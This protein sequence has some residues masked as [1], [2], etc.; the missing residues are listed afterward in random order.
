MEKQNIRPQTKA[1]E[2]SVKNSMKIILEHANSR[3]DVLVHSLNF[4]DADQAM[5][6]LRTKVSNRLSLS[7]VLHANLEAGSKKVNG[8]VISGEDNIQTATF[9]ITDTPSADDVLV[10][11]ASFVRERSFLEVT[12]C[13]T[14]K[15]LD[16]VSDAEYSNQR[17]QNRLGDLLCKNY[18][19]GMAA[20]AIHRQTLNKE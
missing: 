9:V 2:I 6:V 1:S 11:P 19:H 7:D 5:L 8:E 13:G 18:T 4:M 12:L 10:S 15:Q 20:N 16:R 3:N 14:M 17:E